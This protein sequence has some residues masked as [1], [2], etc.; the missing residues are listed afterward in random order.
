MKLICQYKKNVNISMFL[1]ITTA[2][3]NTYAIFLLQDAKN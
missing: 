1:T 3:Q 2:T